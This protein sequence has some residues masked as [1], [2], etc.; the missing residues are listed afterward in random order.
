MVKDF[1]L[2]KKYI[3]AICAAPLI[4]AKAGVLENRI[5]TIYPGLEKE[6]PKPRDAK[7][8]VHDNIITSKAPGT[9]ME[10]ALK[11]VEVLKGKNAARS[12]K[13]DMVVE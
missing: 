11:L 1:D 7:V 6:L 13:E 12:V 8:I 4:L 2:K 5:A 3:A 10:F 9:A